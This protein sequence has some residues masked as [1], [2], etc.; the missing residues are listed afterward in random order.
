[1]MPIEDRLVENL[2]QYA[3]KYGRSDPVT[4]RETAH[5]ILA[6]RQTFTGPAGRGYAYRIAL[7]SVF[8]RAGLTGESR[9]RVSDAI[10]W[11]IAQIK[12]EGVS[13]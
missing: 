5:L 12:R 2:R 13:P 9:K 10:R 7:G 8:D 6:F 1:M 3:R 4:L 11:H